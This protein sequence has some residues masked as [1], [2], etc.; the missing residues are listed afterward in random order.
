[1]VINKVILTVEVNRLSKKNTCNFNLCSIMMF[2]VLEG[3]KWKG[4]TK[5]NVGSYCISCWSMAVMDAL[6]YF[7]VRRM[8]EPYILNLPRVCMAERTQ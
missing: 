2:F 1:M 6:L 7:V 4:E 5:R 3:R 8:S